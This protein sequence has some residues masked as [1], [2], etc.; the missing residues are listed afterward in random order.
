MENSWEEKE[1]LFYKNMKSNRKADV[2]G[3][4]E[5]KQFYQKFIEQQKELKEKANTKKIELKKE[6]RSN[7]LLLP[8]YK[9]P[10]MKIIK[11]EENRKIQ[12]K[13]AEKNI[14]QKYY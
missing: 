2:F 9:S 5:L 10:I 4:E 7:S 12:E 11:K 6:W 1:K 14:K 13:F 8:K 3:K